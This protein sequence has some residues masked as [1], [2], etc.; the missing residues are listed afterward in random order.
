MKGDTACC[1]PAACAAVRSGK[2]KRTQHGD[3]QQRVELPI[4][5][6][7][8]DARF[9]EAPA[10][11]CPV[12]L[13]LCSVI[14]HCCPRLSQAVSVCVVFVSAVSVA[15]SASRLG[16]R[17]ASVE[18]QRHLHKMAL[19]HPHRPPFL[20]RSHM[21]SFAATSFA[22]LLVATSL[23]EHVGGFAAAPVNGLAL[24]TSTARVSLARSTWLPPHSSKTT[25]ATTTTTT[26][27]SRGEGVRGNAAATT[28]GIAYNPNDE[29]RAIVQRKQHEI[30]SLLAAHSAT[31]D[32]LQVQQCTFG[33]YSTST[34]A[35]SHAYAYM[36]VSYPMQTYRTLVERERE[37]SEMELCP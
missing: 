4:T 18:R 32:P 15:A 31:H 23:I 33:A 29:L 6:L 8:L 14:T 9:R 37:R 1:S 27:R 2:R 17:T 26:R 5:P 10:L 20:W 36:H 30:K 22:L 25:A 16:L 28:M 13:S 7:Q 35:G 21:A 11:W 3:T 24:S 19:L 34:A 12:C